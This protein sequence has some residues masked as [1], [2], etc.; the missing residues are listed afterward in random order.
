NLPRHK[1]VVPVPELFAFGFLAAGDRNYFVKNLAA[2]ALDAA[3][4]QDFAGV[5]VHIVDHP[6]VHR[7]VAG[8][9]DRRARLQAKAAAAARRED[10]HIATTGHQ[11]RHTR[12][13]EA[14]RVHEYETLLGD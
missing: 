13:I 11:T 9:F 2:D 8:H 7:R 4:G 5:D 1:L 10:H 12:R 14:G 3:A 6:L